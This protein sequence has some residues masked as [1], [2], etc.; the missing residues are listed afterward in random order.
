[1]KH[2]KVTHGKVTLRVSE[3]GQGPTLVFFNGAGTTQATWKGVIRELRGSYRVVTFDFRS[4]GLSTHSSEISFEHLLS[5]VEAVM[6]KTAGQ[7]PFVV[8]WSMGADLAVWYAAAHPDRVAGLFLVDGA[9][10]VNLV[11]SP[12]DVRRRLNRLSIWISPWIMYLA[13]M[14]YQ[15]TPGEMARLT[16]EVNAR[17]EKILTAYKQ[18]ACPVELVLATRTSREQGARAERTNALWRA[19]G[20]QLAHLYPN[21]PL[22]W[23][24]SSHLLPFTEPARLAQALDAFVQ[25]VEAG[26][27][28]QDVQANAQRS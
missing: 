15:L 2:S 28:K 7:R 26:A 10:P 27:S 23:L 9:L 17:R 11:S 24:D 18:L 16:I 19:G 21:F 4:H 3:A 14:G 5:D 25:R 12:D 13:G 20:E 8:G 1:M 22:Q 6:E